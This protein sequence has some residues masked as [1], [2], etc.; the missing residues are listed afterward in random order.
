MELTG[1]AQSIFDLNTK[2]LSWNNRAYQL[3]GV[4][5]VGAPMTLE[6]AMDLVYPDDIERLVQ[7]RALLRRRETPVEIDYRIIRPDGDLLDVHTLMSL[8]NDAQ[9]Q[10]L[11][12]VELTLDVTG[13]KRT[14]TALMETARLCRL[15]D[16][17]AASSPAQKIAAAEA[18]YFSSGAAPAPQASAPVPVPPKVAAALARKIRILYVEDNMY[19][20]ML[21]DDMMRTRDDTDVRMAQNG[22]EGLEVAE[23]WQPDVLVLDGRLPDTHGIDLLQEM[24]A[25]PGLQKTPAFMCSAET[26][27]EHKIRAEQAGFTG[28][29]SKPVNFDQVFEDLEK[30]VASGSFR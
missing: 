24:R 22:K 28:Y 9:G 15:L 10:P 16:K 1:V 17:S 3:F 20:L 12:Y 11:A 7:A 18:A 5:P 13:R 25:I 6:A 4:S 21:F 26:E 8:E 27:A 2:A 29:W 23:S 14:E 19:N 30:L